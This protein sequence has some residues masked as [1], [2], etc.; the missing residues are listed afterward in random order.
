M[1]AK[2]TIMMMKVT[3]TTTTTTSLRTK[4]TSVLMDCGREGVVMYSDN[5]VGGG[6]NDD[7]W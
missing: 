2:I 5:G 3:M 7:V 1:M 4:E 6:D